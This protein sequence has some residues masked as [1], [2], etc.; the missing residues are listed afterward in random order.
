LKDPAKSALNTSGVSSH[1]QSSE[2]VWSCTFSNIPYEL[3]ST[4]RHRVIWGRSVS[5]AGIQQEWKLYFMYACHGIGW[6]H[7]GLSK[8]VYSWTLFLK[9][10]LVRRSVFPNYHYNVNFQDC[11]LRCHSFSCQQRKEPKK[12]SVKQGHLMNSTTVFLLVRRA[13]HQLE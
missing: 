2:Q 4:S 5:A 12:L 9:E 13:S 6:R 7:R 1:W 10:A 8:P 11:G 3:R